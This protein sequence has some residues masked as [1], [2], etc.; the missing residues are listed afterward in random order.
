LIYKSL[1]WHVKEKKTNKDKNP[2]PLPKCIQQGRDILYLIFDNLT[3]A[4]QHSH[5]LNRWKMV[6]TM[7]I[8][9]EL[10]NPDL[11]RLQC[12]MIF[13]ADWQL[14]LKWHSS[15]GFLPKAKQANTLTP[16]QGGGRKGR[17]AI[18]QALQQVAETE[19]INLNQNQHIVLFLDLRHCFD[20]WSRRATIWHADIKAWLMTISDSTRKP[21]DLR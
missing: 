4:L 13:E 11:Q 20:P 10:G 2:E 15:Y 21:I 19:I 18:D 12:L 5:T 7:F 17:S 16:D 9:K 1:Q 3:L 14:V 8:E 6:W